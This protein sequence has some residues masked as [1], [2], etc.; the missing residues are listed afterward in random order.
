M[1]SSAETSNHERL[2]RDNILGETLSVPQ[3]V[4]LPGQYQAS[5]EIKTIS[6]N[7]NQNWLIFS[8]AWEWC[9]QKSNKNRMYQICIH[10]LIIILFWKEPI[11]HLNVKIRLLKNISFFPLFYFFRILAFYWHFHSFTTNFGMLNDCSI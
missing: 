7:D 10:V 5:V 11:K 3:F 1:S 4:L 6:T 2:Q 9:A 8:Y